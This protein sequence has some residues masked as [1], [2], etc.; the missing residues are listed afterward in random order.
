MALGQSSTWQN[1][2]TEGFYD[3]DLPAL[4]GWPIRTFLP[5]GYEPKYAY[6]LI[7][8]FHEQGSSEE[9]ILQL[10]PQVSRRNFI[11]ISLRGPEVIGLTREGQPRYGWGAETEHLDT[12]HE[13][14]LRAVEQTRRT[15]HV[16][17]ERVFLAGVGEGATLAYRIGLSM[18]EKFAGVVALNGSVPRPQPDAPTFRYPEVRGLK[19]FMA[20]GRECQKTPFE[21]ARSDFR[22][23][24]SAGIE[25]RLVGYDSADPLHP[26]MLRDLN[27]WVVDH[28]SVEC[29]LD[30]DDEEI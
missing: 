27:R 1:R 15:Y 9:R 10:A 4:G 21:T 17:S 8:F 24:Y 13:Y 3:S 18:P 7:V 6:P 5:T 14:L 12:L 19:V 22:L 25:P 2:P 28:V 26:G 11:C 30:T 23:L 16:H 29:P 20:H